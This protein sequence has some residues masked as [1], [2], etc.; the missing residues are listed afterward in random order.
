V[1]ESESPVSRSPAVSVVIATRD[2]PALLRRAIAAVL[3]QDYDGPI[4][5]AVVFDQ[6]QPDTSLNRSTERRTVVVMPNTRTPG[7]PGGR[8]TGISATKGS[9][10][11]FCDD[12]DE[13][14]PGKLTL[15]VEHLVQ[16][17]DVTFCSTG[18]VVDFDGVRTE[19]PSPIPEL[20]VLS[21]LHNR[22]TEAHPSTFVFR[23]VVIDRIGLVD[24]QI[25]GG[26]SEDYDFMIRAARDGTFACLTPPLVSVKWGR[27]SYF[28]NR[29][30]TIIDAQ[31]YLMAKHPEFSQDRRGEARIRGQIA[32]ALAASGRR[33]EMLGEI[34]SVLCRFSL[35]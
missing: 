6:T 32:F 15:Q 27:T 20:T 30:L 24:E 33:R 14:L 19:R 2:R 1:T 31:R 18:I 21:L 8:N 25:P 5:I 22:V 16:H 10:I 13:W 7:L 29:W 28:T 11:A 26:Y 9:L 4:D 35:F 12:D 17:P 23:R 3:D 34:G